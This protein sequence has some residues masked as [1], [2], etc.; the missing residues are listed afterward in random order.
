M[1]STETP[2][3]DIYY[4]RNKHNFGDLAEQIVQWSRDTLTNVNQIKG[5]TSTLCHYNMENMISVVYEKEFTSA[6]TY[7]HN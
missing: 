1:Y 2:E 3:T 6:G 4:I 5:I 7:E